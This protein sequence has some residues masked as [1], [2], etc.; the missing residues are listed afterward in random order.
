MAYVATTA[1]AR[2]G[3]PRHARA[4]AERARKE[5]GAL[6]SRARAELSVWARVRGFVSLRSFRGGLR[7]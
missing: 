7:V 4:N 2:Y 6:L 3:P 1:R 5:L